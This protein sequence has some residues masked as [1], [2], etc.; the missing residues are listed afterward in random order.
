LSVANLQGKKDSVQRNIGL[1]VRSSGLKRIIAALLVYNVNPSNSDS[2]M[3]S[4]QRVRTGKPLFGAGIPKRQQF[5][6]F[7]GER[8]R[9]NY[10]VM[11]LLHVCVSWGLLRTP[12]K[13]KGERIICLSPF[14]SSDRRS[15]RRIEGAL[16]SG[17][18]FQ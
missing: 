2:L 10:E 12:V 14:A 3:F 13:E 18:F 17:R 5:S 7:L 8:K 9:K 1:N 4:G 16:V 11:V 6:N 15:F